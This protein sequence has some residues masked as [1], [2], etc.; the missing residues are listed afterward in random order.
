MPVP[1]PYIFVRLYLFPPWIAP[2]SPMKSLSLLSL[3]VCL[4][5][6]THCSN[7]FLNIE[8][9]GPHSKQLHMAWSVFRSII[10]A[11]CFGSLKGR[12]QFFFTLS[13]SSQLSDHRV[14][15]TVVWIDPDSGQNGGWYWCPVISPSVWQAQRLLILCDIEN[16]LPPKTLSVTNLT[17]FRNH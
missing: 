5:I 2:S 16:H 10:T 4:S 12:T 8:Q 11:A 7:L 15:G 1:V 13:S 9:N 6:L 3:S 17:V 14:F